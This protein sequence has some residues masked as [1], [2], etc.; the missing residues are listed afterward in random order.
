MATGTETSKV[1][2][3]LRLGGMTTFMSWPL[4]LYWTVSPGD[5]RIDA[6]RLLGAKIQ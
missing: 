1:S 5:L 2:P 4:M 6:P 3:A